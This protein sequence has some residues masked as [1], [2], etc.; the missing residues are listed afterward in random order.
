MKVA[1]WPFLWE[2]LIDGL[3]NKKCGK[4]INITVPCVGALQVKAVWC[5]YIR[6]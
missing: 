3:V 4:A 2:R 5:V 1:T 6:R